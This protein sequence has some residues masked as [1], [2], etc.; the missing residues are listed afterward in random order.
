MFKDARFRATQSSVPF[1]ITLEDIWVPDRCPV[2][3]IRLTA[4]EGRATDASPS[5]DRIL[6]S[7]GYVP[8]N[9]VVVSNRANWLR[10]NATTEELCRIAE[11]Y[12]GLSP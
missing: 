7:K 5:L 8:G 11:F 9:I 1:T 6:P 3:G 10:G 12:K 4:S 2:L